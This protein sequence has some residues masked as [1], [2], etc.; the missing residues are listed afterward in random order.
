MNLQIGNEEE[1][2]KRELDAMWAKHREQQR[3]EEEHKRKLA[4][5]NKKHDDANQI[6]CY[7]ISAFIVLILYSCS[8]GGY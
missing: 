6:I 1:K 8:N 4:L 3:V 5:E 7:C 2:R